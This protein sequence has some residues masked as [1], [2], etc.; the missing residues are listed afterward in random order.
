MLKE[1]NK[2]KTINGII[3]VN[4]DLNTAELYDLQIKK[5]F[6]QDEIIQDLTM[7]QAMDLL[8]TYQQEEI[9]LEVKEQERELLLKAAITKHEIEAELERIASKKA[10]KEEL[11][12]QESLN[13][14]PFKLVPAEAVTEENTHLM[15]KTQDGFNKYTE[16]AYG[17]FVH[18][19][20]KLGGEHE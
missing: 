20:V 14:K 15:E 8:D 3:E 2:F 11:D 1:N 6:G 17:K 4:A 7:Q 5:E 13:Q 12:F 16:T 9:D 10:I 19:Q 18:Q